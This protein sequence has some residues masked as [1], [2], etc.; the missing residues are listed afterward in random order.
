MAP[1]K[2]IIQNYNFACGSV[3]LTLKE[4]HRRRIFE[5]KLLRRDEETGG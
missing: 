3:S 4:K 1:P 2:I 5:K